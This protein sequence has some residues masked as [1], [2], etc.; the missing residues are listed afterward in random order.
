MMS[1]LLRF[2]IIFACAAV[3]TATHA[4]D[5]LPKTAPSTDL[6]ATIPQPERDE[7]YRTRR[8]SRRKNV[9][10]LV[11]V[12]GILGSKIEECKSDNSQCVTIWGT[13][14]AIA[15]PNVDLSIRPDRVYR[16]DVVES[17]FFKDVYG[18][19]LDHIRDRANSVIPDNS[20]DPLLT[21]FHYD[22][23]LS[24]SDNASFL[25]Q[26]ICDVRANAPNSPIFIVAHS[27]GGLITKIWAARY[28]QAAC[29]NGKQP[30]VTEIVFVATPHLGSPKA[31]KAIAEGYD[32]L[33]D[34]LSGLSR[35]LGWY[36]RNY[37]LD[38]VNN[39]GVSFPSLYELLPIRTSEYCRTQKPELSTASNP[40]EGQDGNPIN[41]F[42][43][44]TWR[45][46][47]LLHRVG[48]APVR[49]AYYESKLAPLLRQSELLLC[50]IVNFDPSKV[51]KVV[52]LFGREK[53]DRTYGWFHLQVGGNIDRSKI[54]QGDGTV[55]VYSAQNLLVSS[56]RQT[57]EVQA[58]HVKI[59]SSGPV[60]DMIDDWYTEATKRAD[61]DVGR[62]K[63]EYASLLITE[64]AA[65]GN[66]IPISLDAR[67]WSNR[68]ERFAIEVNSAAIGMM[69]YK[70]SEIAGFASIT[71][72]SI[73]RARLYAVAASIASDPSRKLNW[74]GQMAQSAYN[75][76]YFEDAIN[77]AQ[78]VIETARGLPA[79]DPNVVTLQRRANEVIGWAY[80][81]TG[82][83]ERFNTVATAY[84]TQYAVSKDEFKEP[85]SPLPTGN[86]VSEYSEWAAR[87][88]AARV[89]ATVIER[90]IIVPH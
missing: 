86:F 42:D 39:A 18:S 65:S 52:Y 66:L 11:F 68:D 4:Q 17:L 44:E 89:G 76:S 90:S 29:P 67:E 37:I 32:I 3:V 5:L 72:D 59:V 22:W 40:A 74:I 1:L 64:T 77:S 56:T 87:T 57:R 9:P 50:E 24:N 26:R 73:K 41:L 71:L 28:S 2:V 20:A 83:V 45:R 84:S 33:F 15:R 12:P 78:F 53:D 69:G 49:Q 60:L 62:I 46:Y 63:P 38:A 14:A 8:D 27:M 34:E 70:D 7:F 80:L 58:D 19:A 81:R 48:L 51:A 13:P 47:D 36:E 35:F 75:A 21:V 85:K 43:V 25:K 61:L 79:N 88:G 82:D 55:P 31:I 23:R 6:I 16:T 10:R 30:E 54:V